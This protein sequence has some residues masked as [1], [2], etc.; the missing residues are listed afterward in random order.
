MT[1]TTAPR[2][3]GLVVLAALV[4]VLAGCAA[5]GRAPAGRATAGSPPPDAADHRTVVD[6]SGEQVEVPAD[7]QRIVVLN[8]YAPLDALL[9]LGVKPVGSSGDPAADY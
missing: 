7:P 4:A 6:A 2:P 3:V 1:A 5:S 9:A 8:Q